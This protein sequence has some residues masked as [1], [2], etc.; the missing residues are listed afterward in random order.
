LSYDN[1]NMH[2]PKHARWLARHANV[3]LHYTP[4]HASWL[5]QVEV[6]FSLLY[7]AALR[8]A[9][10]TSPW[11]VRDAID[12]CIKVTIP[13]PRRSSGAKRSSIR[14]RHKNVTLTYGSKY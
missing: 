1:L 4:T 13:G 2:K 9:S 10:F 14:S 5:N 7:R 3:H 8:D 11:N 12:A 6:W